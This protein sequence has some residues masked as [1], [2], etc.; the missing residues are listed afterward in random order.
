MKKRV[1]SFLLC[2]FMCV[3]LL[4]ASAQATETAIANAPQIPIEGDVWDGTLVR[5]TRSVRKDGV[6]YTVISTCEEFAYLR[7][8]GLAPAGNYILTNNLILN[9]VIIRWD[10]EGNCTNSE[11]LLEW[12]PIQLDDYRSFT[13]TFDGQGHTISGMYIDSDSITNCGLFGSS[14]NYES[15]TI[16]NLNVVNSFVKTTGE[17]SDYTAN[18]VGGIVAQC[19][20]VV[21]CKF[22]GVV[23]SDKGYAGG[24]VAVAEEVRSC[25]NYGTIIAD[26]SVVGGIMATGFAY[27][28]IN[29]GTV[30]NNGSKAPTGGIVGRTAMGR[31]PEVWRCANYG[32]ITG[33]GITGGISGE[34]SP[35]RC[36]NYGTVTGGDCV[37][38]I[39]G[40]PL[41]YG[42]DFATILSC[43]NCGKIC[44]E[45]NV[46]GIVGESIDRNID[47]CYNIGGVTADGEYAG[48]I[49]GYCDYLPDFNGVTSCYYG[50]GTETPDNLFAF[51]NHAQGG[52]A[53]DSVGSAEEKSF[54]ELQL[55]STFSGWDFE[56]TWAISPDINGGYPYLQWQEELLSRIPVNSVQISETALSLAEGDYAY[57]TATVTPVNA[58]NPSITWSSSDESVA[59]VNTA[60]KVTAISAGTTVITVT[61]EDGGY[62]AICTVT[63]TERLTE[64]YRINSIT[65]RD[66]DGAVLSK[67][68]SGDCLATVSITN[69]ASEG[70]TLVLLAAYSSSG[71]YQGMMWV[72]VADLHVGAT[73]TVTLPVDNADGEI[74]NLKAFTV[75]SFSDLTPLGEAV[76]FLP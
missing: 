48:A 74:E 61:T 15:G 76:S 66:N 5:P 37:G 9:D 52:V 54:E 1:T 73:I 4:P 19:E 20:S 29:Y 46:G 71:R 13:G 50:N 12:I 75:A 10:E 63:V 45:N 11:E 39:S 3:A 33:K 35:E 28:C 53:T 25:E 57:L 68:P 2:A 40:T 43:F 26:A 23:F 24:I 38:G 70:N 60:G 58:N 49:A 72:G 56:S 34:G 18:K 67:I 31:S 65:V 14:G 16:K 62:T 55:Q 30:I 7:D 17:S 22:S 8:G 41:K 51:G 59:T 42:Y 69:L 32:T 44:G 27:K 6:D 21:N 47:F 36:A 64:E